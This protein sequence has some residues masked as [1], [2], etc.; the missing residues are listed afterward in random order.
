VELSE[1]MQADQAPPPVVD[2]NLAAEQAQAQNT[3]VAALQTQAQGDTADLMARFG[4]RMAG[5]APLASIAAPPAATPA[6]NPVAGGLAA[7]VQSTGL[8]PAQF[9]QRAVGAA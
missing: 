3:Q 1:T 6:S 2:P 9:M 8:S 5:G 7:A 4:T